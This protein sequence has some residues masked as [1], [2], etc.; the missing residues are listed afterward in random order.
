MFQSPKHRG[1]FFSNLHRSRRFSF[2]FQKQIRY[3]IAIFW[4]LKFY[5]TLANYSSTT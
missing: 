3:I 2:D 1:L 5:I 4:K